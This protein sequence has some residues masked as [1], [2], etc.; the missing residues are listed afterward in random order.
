MINIKV[1]LRNKTFLMLFI[2]A[3]LAFIYT[4]LSYAGIFPK[5]TEDETKNIIFMVI[6]ILSML[7]IIVDPTTKGIKDSDRA[8][9]YNEPYALPYDVK[10]GVDPDDAE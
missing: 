3:V 6:E 2:P 9:T 5:I 8:M 1:R 10:E 4:V 7:G